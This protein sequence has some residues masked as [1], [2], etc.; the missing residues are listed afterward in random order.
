MERSKRKKD[1]QP[2]NKDSKGHVRSVPR[3]NKN[4]ETHGLFSKYLPGETS[5]RGYR[6]Y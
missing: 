3:G 2:Q 4:A 6:L 1:G 5:E